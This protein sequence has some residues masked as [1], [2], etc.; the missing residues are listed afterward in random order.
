MKFKHLKNRVRAYQ[1]TLAVANATIYKQMERIQTLNLDL[2][3][4]EMKASNL[5]DK[6]EVLK[7][8][9]RDEVREGM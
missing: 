2:T 4:A 5:E 9:Y 8:L 7:D 1:D 6:I 3:I